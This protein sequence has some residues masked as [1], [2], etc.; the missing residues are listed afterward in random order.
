MTTLPQPSGHLLTVAEYAELGEIE[1]GFT[2]LLEGRLLMSP[3]PVPDHNAAAAELLVALRPQ[4]P[5]QLK[6]IP[7]VDID[8]AL[9]PAD[10]PGFSRRPDLVVVQRS[11]RQRVRAEGG[12]LRA[13]EVVVVIEIVSPGSR[14][15]DYVTKRAEYADAGIGHYWIVDLDPPISLLAC[16]LAGELGYRAA[17]EASGVFT[18]SDPFAVRLQLNKLR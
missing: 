15:T 13:A 16:H 3:S 12:L 1:S 9:G 7:D 2:E 10:Q 18:A 11:A 4:L 6:V 8:L 17:P 14:R 5:D